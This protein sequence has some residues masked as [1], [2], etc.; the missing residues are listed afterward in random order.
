MAI[1]TPAAPPTALSTTARKGYEGWIPSVPAAHATTT[2][3]GATGA[4]NDGS[5][6]MTMLASTR[7]RTIVVVH[8]R[9]CL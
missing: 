7:R 9:S 3:A 8:L 5:D 2:G 6:V 1:D 4:A